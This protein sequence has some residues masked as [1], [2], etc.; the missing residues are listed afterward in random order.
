MTSLAALTSVTDEI[1]LGTAILTP[2]RHP[3]KAAQMYGTLSYLSEGRIIAGIGAGWDINEFNAVDMPY[4]ERPQ[5]VR[6]NVEIF[7]KLWNEEGVS[8]DGE[9]FSFEDIKIDPQ[10]VEDPPVFYGGLST[11]AVDWTA[12]MFDGWLPSRLPYYRVEE[13]VELLDRLWDKYDRDG[14]PTV[15]CMPQTSIA[16]DSERAKNGFNFDKVEQEA[17][18][19]KPVRG[20]KDSFTHEEL[21]GYLI[22]GEPAEICEYVERFIELGVDQITFDMRAFFG[23]YQERLELLGDEVIP[24]FK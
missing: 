20:E 6:E 16:R 5:L 8:Y 2:H 23:E 19:R 3:V 15:S 13:R 9:I 10:P 18:H 12:E 1:K 11:K 24:E 17:L 14:T 7:R 21:E 22:W 4:D